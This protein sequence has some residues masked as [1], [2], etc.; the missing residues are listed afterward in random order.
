MSQACCHRGSE[1]V[2]RGGLSGV[3]Q[4]GPTLS[5]AHFHC[6]VCVRSTIPANKT[7]ATNYVLSLILACQQYRCLVSMRSLRCLIKPDFVVQALRAHVTGPVRVHDKIARSHWSVSRLLGLYAQNT[8]RKKRAPSQ[9]ERKRSYKHAIS[10]PKTQAEGI[11]MN[12]KK[13]MVTQR[14]GRQLKN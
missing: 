11:R 10:A 12:E 13:L 2:S 6:F 4:S 1:H 9:S 14:L 8:R 3:S 5:S 7:M